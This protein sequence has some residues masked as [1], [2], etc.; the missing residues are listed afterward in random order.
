MSQASPHSFPVKP[1]HGRELTKWVLR[2]IHGMPSKDVPCLF[3]GSTQRWSTLCLETSQNCFHLL[4]LFA[5]KT[6]HLKAHRSNCK[7]VT[8]SDPTANSLN[9]TKLLAYLAAV[10]MHCRC[11]GDNV[12]V[13]PR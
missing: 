4:S 11:R 10:C 1:A 2:L 13:H 3:L 6:K 12:T 7:A 9:W 5:L 8:R